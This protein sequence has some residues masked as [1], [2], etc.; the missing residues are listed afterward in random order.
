MKIVCDK[1]QKEFEPTQS[2]LLEH[3]LDGNL[4]EVYFLCPKCNAKH[5]ICFHNSETKNLQ[6]LI[7]K[8]ER[9]GD[10]EAVEKNKEKL[11]ECMDTLNNCL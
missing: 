11:K 2:M 10:H 8:S 5:H 7:R 1:C 9:V 6:K 4:I 3:T